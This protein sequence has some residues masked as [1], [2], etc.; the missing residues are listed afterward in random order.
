MLTIA[1]LDQQIVMAMLPP[2][3]G[4]S[5]PVAMDMDHAYPPTTIPQGQP[6][7]QYVPHPHPQPQLHLQPQ[8]QPQHQAQPQPS[9]MEH[10]ESP[11][12]TMEI[13]GVSEPPYQC[14]ICG[15]GFAIPAR[16]ARHHRVHTGEKPFK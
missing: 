6:Q 9:P 8:P 15:K 16:L 5:Y 14:K 11:R 1:F 13:Q 12:E 2:G 4:S 7:P 10:P 3:L